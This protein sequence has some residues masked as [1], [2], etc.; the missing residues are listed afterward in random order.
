M[1]SALADHV[2]A[3]CKPELPRTHCKASVGH[4]P[5]WKLWQTAVAFTLLAPWQTPASAEPGASTNSI[6][7]AQ[8]LQ[9]AVENSPQLQAQGHSIRAVQAMRQ[10]AGEWPDPVLRAGVDNLPVSGN[11]RG[12]LTADTMTM[13]RIAISQEI[14]GSE[15]LDA[16][17]RRLDGEIQ[18]EHQNRRV[19]IAALQRETA[20][21]WIDTFFSDQQRR[22]LATQ[23]AEA[24]LAVDAAIAAY[25]AGRNTQADVALAQSAVATIDDRAI[26]VD[27]QGQVAQAQLARW[28]GRM[29]NPETRGGLPAWATSVRADDQGVELHPAVLALDA[30]IAT[31]LADRDLASA[32]KRPDWTWEISLGQRGGDKANLFSIAVSIP[33]PVATSRRQDLDIAA[34]VAQ[35]DQWVAQRAELIRSHIAERQ[36]LRAEWSSHRDRLRLLDNRLLPLARERTTATLNSYRSGTVS[37]VS[38]VD[39]RRN[40]ID[41]AMQR[42]DIE[43][44]QARTWAQLRYLLPDGSAS[45]YTN[46]ERAK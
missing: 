20:L 37:L 46:T 16:R 10:S 30:Q 29:A 26:Q 45:Q 40:E 8:A 15:K 21:A 35:I 4:R 23:R 36:T 24:T 2:C 28:I 5:S 17:R 25:R 13:R 6:E 14:T 44:E 27:R 12:R 42:L 19:Q 32:A 43:R 33:L 9:I 7:F 41:I 22:V 34:R 38:V 31:A 1:L 18:R 11:D 39:A 3:R